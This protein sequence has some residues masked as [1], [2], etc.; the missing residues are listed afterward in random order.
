LILLTIETA[1]EVKWVAE[2]NCTHKDKEQEKLQFVHPTALR[3]DAQKQSLN[4][5]CVLT[6]SLGAHEGREMIQIS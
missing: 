6:P 3:P 1:D 5:P 2:S 4:S